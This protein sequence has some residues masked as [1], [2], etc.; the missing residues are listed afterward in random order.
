MVVTDM[1]G[2]HYS[3]TKTRLSELPISS[4][5]NSRFVLLSELK[6]ALVN[7]DDDRVPVRYYGLDEH[8]PTLLFN[9]GYNCVGCRHFDPTTYQTIVKA[10]K[11]AK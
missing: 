5:I 2:R 1:E 3:L 10:A 8:D 6:K 9:R 11:A 7:S 4:M